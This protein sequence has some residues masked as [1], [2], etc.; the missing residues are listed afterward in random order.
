MKRKR[1]K[2]SFP[3]ISVFPT[4]GKITSD[5]VEMRKQNQQKEKEKKKTNDTNVFLEFV[6]GEGK[7]ERL[8][9]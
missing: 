9:I 6:L 2:T 1:E 7:G 3:S 4:E 8:L 5:E